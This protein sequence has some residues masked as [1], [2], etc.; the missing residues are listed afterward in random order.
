MRSDQATF[1]LRDDNTVDRIVAEGDVETELPGRAS[2]NSEAPGPKSHE[3]SDRA[4]L[5]MTGTRNQLTTAILSGNVQ[6][7]SEGMPSQGTQAPGSR[8][9]AEAFAGRVTLHFVGQQVLKT[10][11]A[12]DGVRLTQKS[13]RSG[14]LIASSIASSA[15][16]AGAP[17]QDRAQDIEMTAP[18]MDFI[19]KDGHLLDRA[20]TS[21]PP[22]I[23][24]TQPGA[25]RKT[26]ATAA[27]FIAKFTDKN[28]LATLHGEPDARIVSSTIVSGTIASKVG[29]PVPPDRASTSQMLD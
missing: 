18:V 22:R 11:H 13:S 27:K 21:G 14:A 15:T 19:V 7:A 20:E 2:S 4:E 9:P 1:F 8:Q 28:R 25:N 10:V 23:V 16:K 3:R 24:I 26:V 12:E 17:S 6:L 5:F 29:A